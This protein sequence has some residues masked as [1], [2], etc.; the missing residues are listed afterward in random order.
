MTPTSVFRDM[1]LCVNCK[2][3]IVACKVKHM[4]P[5]YPDVPLD[6]EPRGPNLIQV[7]PIGPEIRGDLV[8][9]SF[10][11]VSCMHCEDPPCIKVC[12]F[13][14]I[15]KEPEM[16]ITLV[17][18]E[19]CVGCKACLWVCPYGAP[20]FDK[21]GKVVL[22]NLCIDRLREGKKAACEAA[23]QAGAIFVGSMD[24]IKEIKARHALDRIAR[25]MTQWKSGV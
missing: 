1:D 22:C 2:S 24:E 14:A 11:S 8:C 3:C 4:F 23:C 18:R 9:Q 10:V 12:P 20:S 13:S 6:P 5:P 16:H 25:D 17:D 15:R 21:D 7:Y 19:L